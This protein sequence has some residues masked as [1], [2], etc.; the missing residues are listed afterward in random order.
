MLVSSRPVL[1][2][3]A[4]FLIYGGTSRISSVS[5]YRV[6][7]IP[8]VHTRR[9][10]YAR[11][12]VPSRKQHH[13]ASSGA[14]T[15]L[16]SSSSSVSPSEM[17]EDTSQIAINLES[18][19]QRIEQACQASSRSIDSVRLVAVSKTKPVALL[20]AAYASG[21]R[22][23]GENYVQELVEKVPL[24]PSDISWHFIG[25]LQSNK[26]NA[27]VQAFSCDTEGLS[28][29]TV[30][31]ISSQKLANKLNK[32]VEREGDG[33]ENHNLDNR[34]SVFV[35]INTS[36]EDSKSGVETGDECIA[37]CRHIVENCPQLA[38][39]GLMTIGA[40]GDLS[41]FD[42]LVTC[43]NQV[44]EALPDIVAGGLELSMGMS[45]DFEAAIAKGATNI[46]VGSTIF[47]ERDYTSAKK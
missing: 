30:E 2:T 40:P 6:S 29:L 12:C 46:R 41:C 4:S 24:L 10:S 43:R 18:V 25:A 13:I 38:L 39:K 8:T 16:R 7:L 3:A 28:R 9:L 44:F 33:H 1:A 26:V 22:V 42:T 32:A 37:L 36:G 21:Q 23:F 17:K 35:Q 19:R 31:T 47:G 34:L 45:G 15:F 27:L 20:E 14:F 11:T 5:A